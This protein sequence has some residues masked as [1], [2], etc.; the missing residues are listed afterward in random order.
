MLAACAGGRGNLIWQQQ[1]MRCDAGT[2]SSAYLIATRDVVPS[3]LVV[4][5]CSTSH[6]AER[7]RCRNR[8]P[9]AAVGCN[10]R[11]L[12][13]LHA[14][15]CA[16]GLALAFCGAGMREACSCSGCGPGCALMAAALPARELV[17]VR[18][19][20][21]SE[22]ARAWGSTPAPVAAAKG[23]GCTH[24]AA[25]DWAVAGRGG[26]SSSCTMLRFFDA[27]SMV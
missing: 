13:R 16:R 17:A 8:T 26:A 3:R 10:T 14:A 7:A 11:S 27:H 18:S 21:C 6:A 2:H 22:R 4:P 9:A 12:K 19:D 24:T 15:A 20:A 25:A 1:H 23:Q 5:S